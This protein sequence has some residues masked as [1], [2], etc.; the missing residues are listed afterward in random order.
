MVLLAVFG[1]VPGATLWLFAD[2]TSAVPTF[3]NIIAILILSPTFIALVKDY[4]GRHMGEGDY[5]KNF[6]VFYEEAKK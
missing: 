2:F 3:I 6:K 1:E 5:D 4:K